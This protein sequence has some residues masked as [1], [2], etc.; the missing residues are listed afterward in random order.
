MA[1]VAPIPQ[2]IYDPGTGPVTVTPT[3]ADVNK[4]RMSNFEAVRHDSIT[5]SGLRQSMLERVDRVLPITFET[6]PWTD[7][8]MWEAFFAYAIEGGSFL[9]YPDNTA[10][11]YQTWELVDDKV[12]VSFA[13]VGLAKFTMNMRLVPGGASH[14]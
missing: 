2:F 14:V 10:T 3:Y 1:A 5:S 4:P 7:L 6:V 13:S 12:A 8:A 11:A 9:Y